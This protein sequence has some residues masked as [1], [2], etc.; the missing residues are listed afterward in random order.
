[1][2]QKAIFKAI[3]DR[4][5]WLNDN[6][7]PN[8][9][10]LLLILILVL[11]FL[12]L[13]RKKEYSRS[14][15]EWR[16][17]YNHLIRKFDLTINELDLLNRMAAFLHDRSRM[18][19]LLTNRNT[20]HH[21]LILLKKKEGDIPRFSETLIHKLF[22]QGPKDM[23]EGFERF[24]GLGRPVRFISSDGNVYGGQII[25]REDSKIILGNVH[26]LESTRKNYDIRGEGRLFIQDFRGLISHEIA[27]KVVLS[28][29][30]F[31]LNLSHEED[32]KKNSFHLPDVYLYLPG[33]KEPV[34]TH[35]Y[36]IS[37]GSGVVENP[38][39][40]LKMDE[41]VKIALQKDSNHNYNVN[42]VV[43]WLSLNKR[44]A[45]LKFGYLK[46]SELED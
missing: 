5:L 28:E 18:N 44:Y 41:S 42:A 27:E 30:S 26:S 4:F 29:S 25:L 3:Q 22:D 32:L 23:P 46:M 40:L 37:E 7:L 15:R 33:T 45:K 11:L 2:D 8:L 20:F 39:A 14:V 21:A 19:L 38:G 16:D 9:L 24:F 35:F 13:Y 17:E 36:R 43:R 34:K 31:Q 12:V 6:V 1:M 10:I